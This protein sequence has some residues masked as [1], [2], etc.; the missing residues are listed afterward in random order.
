MMTC[1]DKNQMN[2]VENTIMS[3]QNLTILSISQLNKKVG[4]TLQAGFSGIWVSGEISNW[5]LAASGHAYFLLKDAQAQV[6]CALFKGRMRSVSFI[7][8]E[9]M[10]VEA[11]VNVNL[12]APRGE[13]QLTVENLRLAGQG[14]LFLAFE[15][16]KQQL[17][18][19]GL[20][21]IER[22]RPIP[23]QPRAIGIIT[24]PQAAALRDVCRHKKEATFSC[25]LFLY[26][27]Q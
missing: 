1:V 7:P 4:D 15:Q 2:L 16:L 11:Y 10:Q 8:K 24:S 23:L 17:A 5:T 9:G 12:Y 3:R 20:F 22:K 25:R 26:W 14:D 27:V 19:E 21:A 13:F 6:R 18:A